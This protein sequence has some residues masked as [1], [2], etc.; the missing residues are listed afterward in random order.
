MYRVI[1]IVFVVLALTKV[2][3]RYKDGLIT[4]RRFAGWLVFWVSLAV[5]G[6]LPQMT[7]PLSQQ[8]GVGRGA[9]LFFFLA[10]VLLS[11]LLLTT[12]QQVHKL[13]QDVTRLV[14]ALA[15]K[16]LEDARR[17][18]AGRIEQG[19]REASSPLQ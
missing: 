7:D 10:I 19:A 11:Y 2:M 16:D 9:D 14:R 17:E 1:L 15:L 13:E 3:L 4:G 8:L 18:S 5:I 6:S 12:Y